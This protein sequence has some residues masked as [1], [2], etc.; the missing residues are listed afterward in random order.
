MGGILFTMW[1]LYFLTLLA[2]QGAALSLPKIR[3]NNLI[4]IIPINTGCLNQCTYCKTKHARGDLRSYP[5]EEIV[6]R[7]KQVID[8]RT[9]RNDMRSRRLFLI[10]MSVLQRVW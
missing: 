9:T 4:E 2:L 7:L 5:I 1:F 10:L 6:D 3:K 8:G